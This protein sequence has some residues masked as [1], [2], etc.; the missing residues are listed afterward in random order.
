MPP[1]CA[2]GAPPRLPGCAVGESTPRLTCLPP[3]ARL[4]GVGGQGLEGTCVPCGGWPRG[5]PGAP[6]LG[7]FPGWG[8]K[9]GCG[10]KSNL[11]LSPFSWPVPNMPCDLPWGVGVS[12]VWRPNP[13][14]QPLR[15][16][17]GTHGLLCA[18]LSDP[19]AAAAGCAH[20]GAPA[21][22]LLWARQIWNVP[23]GA[24]ARAPPLG[25]PS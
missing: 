11:S 19:C 5:T 23:V 13:Q 17:L 14:S 24:K 9:P 16:G 15:E 25:W 20:E 21:P 6:A 18:L 10:P 1:Q 2:I 3:I 7:V 4:G 22:A 8:P 12:W